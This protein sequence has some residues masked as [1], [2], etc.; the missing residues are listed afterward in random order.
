MDD[1]EGYKTLVEEVTADVVETAGE[2]K[3][4]MEPGDVTEL[5]QSHDTVFMDEELLLMDMQRK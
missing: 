4:E 5:M 1:F 2:L 3:L